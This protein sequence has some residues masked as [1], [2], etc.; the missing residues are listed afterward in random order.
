[1]RDH[2]QVAHLIR[3]IAAL[4]AF[5]SLIASAVTV[6]TKRP[7]DVNQLSGVAY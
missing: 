1:V 7:A 2:W 5:G 3:T 4:L 6:P